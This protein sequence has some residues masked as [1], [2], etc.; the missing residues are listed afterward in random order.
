M[1]E[2]DDA[3]RKRPKKRS[4]RGVN[5]HF[6]GAFNAASATQLVFQR[7]ASPFALLLSASVL[8]AGCGD[9]LEQFGGPTMGSS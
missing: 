2:V 3:R 1:N 4:L 9:S 6:E 8:L 7:S 5:E